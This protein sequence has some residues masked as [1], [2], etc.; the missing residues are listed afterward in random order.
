MKIEDFG[1]KIGG[2]AKDRWAEYRMRLAAVPENGITS[3]TLSKSF[4]EPAYKTLLKQGVDPVTLATV[5]SVRDSVPNKPTGG[6]ELLQWGRYVRSMRG[7]CMNLLTGAV[8]NDRVLEKLRQVEGPRGLI[9]TRVKMYLSLGHDRS[10]KSFSLTSGIQDP[11]PHEAGMPRVFFE[12]RSD[13]LGVTVR[14]PSIDEAI[15]A[16]KGGIEKAVEADKKAPTRFGLYRNKRSGQISIGRKIGSDIIEIMK[17]DN[18]NE[19]G[20]YMDEHADDL[21]RRWE[22]MRRS[23]EERRSGNRVRQGPDR[24]MG[25]DIPPEEFHETF[26]FRGVEFGKQVSYVRRQEDLNNAY[27]A[28]MDMAEAIGCA[29]SDLSLDGNLAIGFG[30]RGR[31]GRGAAAAHFEPLKFVINLTMNN[32]AGCLGHEWFHAL[33]CFTGRRIG[34]K[35]AFATRI[36]EEAARSL[37]LEDREEISCFRGLT[38][39]IGSTGMWDRSKRQ[40]RMRSGPYWSLPEEMGARAFESWLIDRLE[41]LGILNDY[42]VNITGEDVY[43]AEARLMGLDEDRYPYPKECEMPDI[44]RAFMGLFDEASPVMRNMPGA[45][46]I[47]DRF[48]EEARQLPA[49][50]EAEDPAAPLEE[51]DETEPANDP[52]QEDAWTQGAFDFEVSDEDFNF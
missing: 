48:H 24:R 34:M 16:L 14:G 51:A 47:P 4:P 28:L 18:I 31:G 37:T 49:A 50:I 38:G 15:E 10:L 41:H 7:L 13:R 42:L 17:F 40:D 21:E 27:D 1:E 9:G 45:F 39:I 22:E 20:R 23:P 5:R 12:L 43:A 36:K 32:G 25:R 29:P 11:A 33:D 19:A 26:K 44:R 6:A 30:S 2:A 35:D 3:T 46:E 52:P 8:D